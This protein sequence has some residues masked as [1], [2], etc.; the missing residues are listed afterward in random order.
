MSFSNIFPHSVGFCTLFIVSFSVQKLLSPACLFLLLFPL[1]EEIDAEK[2]HQ[3]MSEC[4]AYV[5]Y[6]QCLS[7]A[8]RI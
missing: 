2:Y 3:D 7:A 8:L 5:S 6:N 1:P 4:T